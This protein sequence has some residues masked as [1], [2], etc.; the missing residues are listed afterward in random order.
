MRE[1]SRE[2]KL[3]SNSSVRM[4]TESHRPYNQQR[5]QTDGVFLQTSWNLHNKASIPN[6]IVFSKY[7]L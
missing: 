1:V 4:C 5:K 2:V 6:S 7:E 3:H